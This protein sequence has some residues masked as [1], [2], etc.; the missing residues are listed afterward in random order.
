MRSTPWLEYFPVSLFSTIMGLTGFTLSL[1][2][3]ET[4]Y[5]LPVPV[6]GYV[7]SGVLLLFF[8]LL[9]IYITKMIRFFP[10]VLA[11]FRHPVRGNFMPTI[12]ISFLLLSAAMLKINMTV[13]EYFWLTGVIL[14]F[15]FTLL[16]LS[17]WVKQTKYEI[18]QFNPAWFIPII[19]NILVP[20]A[21]TTH[22]MTEVSWFFFSIGMVFWLPMLTIFLYRIIFHHPLPEK[23]IPTFFILMAP[24]AVGF[25]SYVKLNGGLDNLAR[26]LYYFG[27]FMFAFILANGRMFTK[28]RFYLSWWAYSFP[29]AAVCLSTFMYSENTGL[30]FF[31]G[32]FFCLF[33]VLLLFILL[34][35]YLT[36]KAAGK[37]EICVRED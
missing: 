5:P 33:I 26:M 29:L 28:I 6:S 8:M 17:Q 36:L 2:K 25:I 22:K 35:L 19:G 34:L 15:L 11:E 23:L 7:L 37:G 20:V 4:V 9:L 12:S 3:L 24:P 18:N 30:L 16:I 10:A 27:L 32:L 13:S 1:Q 21:G 31:R 14:H